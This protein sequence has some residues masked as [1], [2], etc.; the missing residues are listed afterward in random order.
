MDT[1]LQQL[2]EFNAKLAEAQQA[3]N[4]LAQEQGQPIVLSA[5]QPLFDL[6]VKQVYWSQYTPYFN[7]GEPCEFSVYNL[8]YSKGDEMFDSYPDDDPNWSMGWELKEA[9]KPFVAPEDAGWRKYSVTEIVQLE[10]YYREL[11]ERAV[12]Q[13]YNEVTANQ[14]AQVRDEVQTFLS[15]N[16]TLL[17]RAFGDH[18][19]VLVKSDGTFIIEDCPHD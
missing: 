8:Y 3:I 15:Q 13:G 6:G 17:E 9:F 10:N 19:S 16:E 5:L 18:V 14:M 2:Q 7:D 1:A 4:K 12:Q 11:H